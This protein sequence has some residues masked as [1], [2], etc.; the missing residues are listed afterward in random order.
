MY[1]DNKID[2][3]PSSAILVGLLA[4]V[5]GLAACQSDPANPAPS[6]PAA[7]QSALPVEKE[8]AQRLDRLGV[9]L[10]DELIQLLARALIENEANEDSGAYTA[11]GGDAFRAKWAGTYR[12]EVV[13]MAPRVEWEAFLDAFPEI[14]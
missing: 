7:T 9:T 12:D 6:D 14:R 2:R 10:D 13:A 3:P 1:T 5:L 8:V 11:A 4:S